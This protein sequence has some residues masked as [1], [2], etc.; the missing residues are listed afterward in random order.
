LCV[1][2]IVW[3]AE[4]GTTNLDWVNAAVAVATT[5]AAH[6]SRTVLGPLRFGSHRLD[7]QEGD[8]SVPQIVLLSQVEQKR[9]LRAHHPLRAPRN[10][11]NE[12]ADVVWPRRR[13]QRMFGRGEVGAGRK[14]EEG[15]QVQDKLN[16]QSGVHC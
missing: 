7:P 6:S 13:L 9:G 12:S 10:P 8:G 4:E 1:R 11:N 5:T 3:G 15:Q 2:L 16:N 14:R